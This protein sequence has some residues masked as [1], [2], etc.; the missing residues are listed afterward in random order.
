[1]SN[2]SRA[3]LAIGPAFAS[4]ALP[5]LGQ[6][7]GGRGIAAFVWTGLG[8]LSPLAAIFG[9]WAVGL[10]VVVHIAAA[11]D[12]ARQRP[13]AAD[14]AGVVVSAVVP[15]VGLVALRV[16]VLEP[17]KTPSSSMEPTT[18]IGDHIYIDKLTTLFRAPRRGEVIVFRQP[19]DPDRDYYKRVVAVAGDTVEVRCDKLYINGTAATLELVDAQATYRD[20]D[21]RSS[22]T[23]ERAASRYRETLDGR[24]YEVFHARR[25]GDVTSDGPSMDF[26]SFD[27]ARQP[28]SCSSDLGLDPHPAKGQKPGELLDLHKP[29]PTPCDQQVQYVVPD[30]HVFAM[31]DNRNNSNDSRFWGSVPIE[32]VKGIA[33]GVIWPLGH[34]GAIR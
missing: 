33:V 22:E 21:E 30:G 14:I 17:F 31:G 6:A 24:S 10:V 3:G 29:N 27:R 4:L 9:V 19:C 23:F 13:G 34:I 8:A 20:Y 28:P 12:A 11:V 26:P 1:M 18:D 5:G 32:N 25:E 7:L 2:D 16:A 15:V